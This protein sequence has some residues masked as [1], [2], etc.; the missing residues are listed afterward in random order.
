M[1]EVNGILQTNKRKPNNK[2]TDNEQ[3]ENK[4]A[5]GELITDDTKVTEEPVE[6]HVT[7]YKA[8]T[9]TETIETNNKQTVNKAEANKK[10]LKQSSI[11]FLIEKKMRS[12]KHES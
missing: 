5:K 9:T 10:G 6:P 12:S 7:K 8:E 11:K 1:I 2:Q 3:H 4:K